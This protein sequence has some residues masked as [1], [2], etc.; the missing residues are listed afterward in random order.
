MKQYGK[1][2]QHWPGDLLEVELIGEPGKRMILGRSKGLRKIEEGRRVWWYADHVKHFARGTD[3]IQYYKF[4]L[5]GEKAEVE[6]QKQE[7]QGL[8]RAIEELRAP[9]ERDLS[10]LAQEYMPD[11]DYSEVDTVM[12]RIGK[13]YPGRDWITVTKHEAGINEFRARAFIFGIHLYN[14]RRAP[15]MYSPA[16]SAKIFNSKEVHI[17][18]EQRIFESIAIVHGPDLYEKS[19]TVT[20]TEFDSAVSGIINFIEGR[21]TDIPD[22]SALTS[23]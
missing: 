15:S 13:N 6:T 19:K 9:E 17:P 23:F 3:E 20:Q 18:L 11:W 21:Q 7:E 4:L 8:A 1:V 16:W 12:V 10:N 5:C 14:I 2:L 22:L